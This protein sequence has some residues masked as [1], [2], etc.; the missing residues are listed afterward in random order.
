[1]KTDLLK[2]TAT[3]FGNRRSGGDRRSYSYTLHI[4]ERRAGGRD[5]RQAFEC[6]DQNRITAIRQNGL[7]V[8]STTLNNVT[9]V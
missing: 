3:G 8:L 1:M 9:A 2:V 6:I 7:A 5:R 4:P